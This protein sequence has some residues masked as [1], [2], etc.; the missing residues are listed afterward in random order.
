MAGRLCPNKKTVNQ[1]HL[2]CS[3]ISAKLR[4]VWQTVDHFCVEIFLS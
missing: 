1:Y 3:K 4:L 2:K